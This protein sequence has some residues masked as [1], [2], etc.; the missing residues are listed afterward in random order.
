MTKWGVKCFTPEK[1]FYPVP[2]CNMELGD[3]EVLKAPPA[4]RIDPPTERATKELMDRYHP[5]RHR[6]VHSGI[7][8]DKAGALP[9]TVYYTQPA[10]IKVMFHED[11]QDP[12]T[13][14]RQ[15]IELKGLQVTA[16]N[17]EVMVITFVDDSVVAVVTVGEVPDPIAVQEHE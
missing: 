3:V 5:V 12:V 15:R 16:H 9:P 8:K 14:N 4:G 13:E 11:S 1:S 2:K 7:T 10:Y 17:D 6:T